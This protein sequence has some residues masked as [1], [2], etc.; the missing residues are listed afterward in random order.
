MRND[1]ELAAIVFHD[2]LNHPLTA[3]EVFRF[4]LRSEGTAN[5]GQ[6]IQ[7]RKYADALDRLEQLK[8]QGIIEE[9]NGFYFLAGRIALY[10][11][12][13][14]RT[15][16]ADQKWRNVRGLLSAMRMAP[17]IRAIALSGS[18]GRGAAGHES[19]IDIFV[20]TEKNRIWTGRFFLTLFTLFS[21]RLR[22]GWYTRL[23]FPF[24]RHG[25]GRSV[26]NKICLHHY[27]ADGAQLAHRNAY[28]ASLHAS[29][30][31]LWGREAFTRFLNANGWIYGYLPHAVFSE[32]NRRMVAPSHVL[33]K[34]QRAGE[35]FLRGFFGN[36]FENAIGLLQKLLIAHN[37]LTKLPG[38][39]VI[40]GGELAFHPT[41]RDKDILDRF[42]I[43]MLEL[44]SRA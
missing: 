43:K 29:L 2:T 35:F 13:M 15:N 38:N 25:A 11:S 28:T 27:A 21:W 20:I 24:V 44:H 36:F 19:D 3:W 4:G 37:P 6:P 39:V 22:P 40:E 8:E 33:R 41:T 17:F 16:I 9:K 1:T 32:K 42:A 18:M 31:P 7:I 34:L 30:M 23:F 12:R 26:A 10:A 5:S 14:Q